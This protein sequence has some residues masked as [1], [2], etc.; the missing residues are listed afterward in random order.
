MGL[1]YRSW[2]WMLWMGELG[3]EGGTGG[4]AGGWRWS[5]WT[6][7]VA[8]GQGSGIGYVTR[9]TLLFSRPDLRGTVLFCSFSLVQRLGSRGMQKS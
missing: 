9:S 2:Q 4:S 3:G 5:G 1:F 7:T 8:F 6:W